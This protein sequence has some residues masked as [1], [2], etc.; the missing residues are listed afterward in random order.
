MEHQNLRSLVQY[1]IRYPQH[2]TLWVCHHTDDTIIG[3]SHCRAHNPIAH[4]LTDTL[5]AATGLSVSVTVDKSYIQIWADTNMPLCTVYTPAWI[6][7]VSEYMQRYQHITTKCMT[8]MINT[9][10]SDIRVLSRH[11]HSKNG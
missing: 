10:M 7:Y 1:I 9:L 11:M 8:D 2:F 6:Y 4:W 3:L 5:L